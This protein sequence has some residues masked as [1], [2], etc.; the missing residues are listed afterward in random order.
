M[1]GGRDLNPRATAPRASRPII[2]RTT[3]DQR[4]DRCRADS[5][6]PT[7]SGRFAESHTLA[8]AQLEEPGAGDPLQLPGSPAAPPG[9]RLRSRRLRNG[10]VPRATGRPLGPP[11]HRSFRSRWSDGAV[12]DGGTFPVHVGPFDTAP[13]RAH[14]RHRRTSRPRQNH[15]DP[16]PRR[17]PGRSPASTSAMLGSAAPSSTSSPSATT[18]SGSQHQGCS[19]GYRL[20]DVRRCATTEQLLLTIDSDR[21]VGIS[22][23]SKEPINLVPRGLVVA[24][25]IYALRSPATLAVLP[26]PQLKPD[27]YDSR[28]RFP[29][30]CFIDL[31]SPAS[32]RS[33]SE[34]TESCTIAGTRAAISS[35]SPR[36]APRDQQ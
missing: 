17:D 19:V 3:G 10:R 30:G 1:S 29:Y 25:G 26:E 13:L 14:G 18:T 34:S 28:R 32:T 9:S 21:P 12:T 20:P 4:R 27:A 8:L 22:R 35:R 5:R 24:A 6:A 33:P 31:T 2:R 11:A 23:L 15:D 7:S 36:S 16:H